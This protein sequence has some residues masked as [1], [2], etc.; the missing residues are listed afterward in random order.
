[1]KAYCKRYMKGRFL[2]FAK[3]PEKPYICA[4]TEHKW[5]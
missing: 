5:H 4:K 1:M 3:V 2:T